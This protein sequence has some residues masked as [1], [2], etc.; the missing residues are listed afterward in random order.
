MY[1][2]GECIVYGS[3]DVCKVT[4]I[5][6]KP[7]LGTYYVLKPLYENGTIYTPAENPK[8]FM[9]RV[10][11]RKEA[12]HLIDTI[13]DV[14]PQPNHTKNLQELREHY[15]AVTNT[16]NC[17]DLIGLTVSIHAKKKDQERLGRKLGQVDEK[18]MKQAEDTLFGEFAIALGI[19]KEQVPG[20]ISNRIETLQAANA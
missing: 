12:E 4:D 10:I 8:V 16:H 2:V 17:A 11:S 3:T 18:F 13:P 6:E 19:P 5:T 20:Y 15:R 9:R 14:Q 7:N 1:Q